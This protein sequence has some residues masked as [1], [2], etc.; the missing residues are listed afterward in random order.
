MKR[1]ALG[2]VVAIAYAWWAA[3]VAAFSALAY[4][5]LAVPSLTAIIAYASEGGFSLRR[6]DLAAHYRFRAEGATVETAAPWLAVLGAALALE[7]WGLALGGRS[8]EVPTLS[9]VVDHL[10]ATHVERAALYVLWLAA[11]ALP[12][13]GLA[14]RDERRDR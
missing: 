10:L 13:V 1:V 11:G 14:R 8:V 4:V 9:T 12:V 6:R 7:V 3:G 2:A 5:L